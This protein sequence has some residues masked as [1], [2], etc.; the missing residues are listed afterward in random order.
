MKCGVVGYAFSQ[1][2]VSALFITIYYIIG[3]KVIDLKQYN[4]RIILSDI[5]SIIFKGFGYMINMVWQSIYFQGGTLVVRLT[6][7]PESVALFNTARTACRSIS[8]ILNI[9]NGSVYPELQYEYG[10]K[11]MQVVH[12][13]FRISI[14]ISISIGI[15]GVIFLYV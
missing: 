9:I 13:L 6:L 10:Q 7:G 2:I 8:Q 11:N 15:I 3:C 5:K 12:R 14:L 4:G 1:L